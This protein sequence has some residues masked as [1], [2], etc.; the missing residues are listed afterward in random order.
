MKFIEKLMSEM[1]IKEKV[2]QTVIQR[3]ENYIYDEETAETKLKEYPIGG[4]FV[5]EEIIGSKAMKGDDIINAIKRAE[6]YSKIPPIICADTEFGC[7]YM[8][9]DG[10]YSNFPWQMTL[11]ATA[12]TDY[13]YEFGKTWQQIW[14]EDSIQ[15]SFY[16]YDQGQYRNGDRTH[17]GQHGA[18]GGFDPLHQAESDQ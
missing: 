9:P 12:N 13:A 11:G 1:T 15:Q 18:G 14:C 3:S 16:S 10:R 17:C 7:G 5:G 2:Y 8:F 4:F 6:K